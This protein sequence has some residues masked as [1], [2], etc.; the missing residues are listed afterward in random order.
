MAELLFYAGTMDSGK[1]TLALQAH[2]N[3]QARARSGLLL[4][5]HDRSGDAT[6]TSRLGLSAPALSIDDSMDLFQLVSMSQ[7]DG[8]LDYLVCDEAQFYHPHQVDQLADIVDWLGIDVMAFGIMTDF[9]SHLFPASARLV[10]LADRIITPAVPALC[11]CGA[12][13]THQARLVGGVMVTHGETVVIGDV[14]APEAAVTYVVLC[15]RHYRAG[16]IAAP[17]A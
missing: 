10:E 5:R 13:A 9:R 12:S 6:V 8:L 14:D 7:H 3:Q 11:W 2:H 16:E 4:T 15:R 1:S 17:G